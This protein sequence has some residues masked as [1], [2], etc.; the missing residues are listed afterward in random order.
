MEL[1]HLRRFVRPV[2]A[3]AI[4]AAVAAP[5]FAFGAMGFGGFHGGMRGGGHVV[6]FRPPP[7]AIDAPPAR[8]PFVT[9]PRPVHVR[10]DKMH[11]GDFFRPG[12]FDRR[13]RFQRRPTLPWGWWGG[14]G[15]GTYAVG[16]PPPVAM[17]EPE[18][19]PT[20]APAPKPAVCPELLTWSP[21]LG[22]AIRRR[23]CD[24]APSDLAEGWAPPTPRG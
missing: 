8:P 17:A 7:P 18:P 20:T 16:G 6:G 9:A 10:F 19:E 11:H 1:T 13:G 15:Y 22:R 5:A 14:V 12:R 24:E 4:A 21:R 3:A 2:A 23:L